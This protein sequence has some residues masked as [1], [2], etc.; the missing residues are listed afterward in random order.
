MFGK[1]PPME[2]SNVDDGTCE[3]LRLAL[4]GRVTMMHQVQCKCES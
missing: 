1:L 4:Q 3:R 2:R